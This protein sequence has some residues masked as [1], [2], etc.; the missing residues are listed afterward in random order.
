MAGQGPVF[1]RTNWVRLSVFNSVYQNHSA[2]I[3]GLRQGLIFGQR[4]IAGFT[5]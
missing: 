4:L 3:A 5:L 2:A 1:E